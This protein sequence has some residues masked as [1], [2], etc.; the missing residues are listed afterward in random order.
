LAGHDELTGLFNRGRLEEAL[1]TALIEARSGHGDSALLHIDI[2]RFKLIRNHAGHAAS[3]RLLRGVADVLRQAGGPRHLLAHVEGDEFA[4]LLRGT[5]LTAAADI[6]EA[7]RQALA[8]L[9][10]QAD[11]NAYTV[12]SS[13]GLVAITSGAESNHEQ[14]MS[15][16]QQASY[17]ARRRG[18]NIIHC[19]REDDPELLDQ[20]KIAQWAPRI[21]RALSQGLFRLVFQP[22]LRIADMTID[23]YEVLVRMLDDQGDMLSPALFIP[24][25][26]QLGMIHEIDRWVISEAIE[27]LHKAAPQFPTL[28]FNINLSGRAFQDELLLPAIRDSLTKAGVRPDR[29]TFEITETAAINNY[30]Q[31]REMVTELRA[32]GCRFALDDFGAGF[33]SYN[34]LKEFPFDFLKI[35]GAFITNLANDS[36]DQVLVKSMVDVAHM[37]GKKTTAEFVGDPETLALLGS[38]G[39]DHAQGFFIGKPAPTI[40][41]GLPPALRR[42]PRPN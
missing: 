39:V 21:R 17:V 41:S 11:T 18:G 20:K 29:I 31:T 38:Y 26:E 34:Y 30:E 42:L 15:H 1:E 7:L 8:R 13:I 25:A 12:Q 2:D 9:R 40:E 24:V 28:A 23:H 5:T 22:V 27:L 14:L 33:A 36:T 19:Y 4:V 16:A 6:A 37:L 35:D 32:L 10:F 3:D